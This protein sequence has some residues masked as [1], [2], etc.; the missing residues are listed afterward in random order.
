M[1]AQDRR[2]GPVGPQP[3]PVDG[4]AALDR[5]SERLLAAA[6][7]LRVA[8]AQTDAERRTAYRL[9]HE[10]V[11]RDGWAGGDAEGLEHDAYDV[12]AL[13]ICAWRGPDP[14]GTVRVVLP[15]EGRPLP[16]EAAFGVTVEPRGAVAEA[17][18][19]VIASAHRGDP[20]H[21]AWGAL[22]ARAWLELRARGYSVLAGAATPRMVE[23]LRTLGLPFETLG[24]ARA[25]WG[26]NRHPVRLDPAQGHPHW[27]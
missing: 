27:F 15:V 10:Q 23:R 21:A 18:R 9:R 24:P 17:G 8:V 22:F 7:G 26:E 13:H 14:V 11:V 1:T 4:V 5:L 19:L 3:P 12:E 16:V 20:V 6:A 2:M 25:Y